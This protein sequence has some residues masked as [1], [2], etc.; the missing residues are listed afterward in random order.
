MGQWGGTLTWNRWNYKGFESQTPNFVK[1]VEAGRV[2]WGFK[3]K[4]RD[5]ITDGISI[6]DVQWILKYLGPITDKQIQQGLVAS[7]ASQ[8]ET[9]SYTRTLRNRI[10]QLQQVVAED[11]RR[12]TMI[13]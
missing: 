13:R 2:E 5:D 10:G 12:S 8:D 4:H 9:D 3:G 6:A 7:G 1:G 11:H